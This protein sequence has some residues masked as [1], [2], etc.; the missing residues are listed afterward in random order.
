MQFFKSILNKL[1][2]TISSIA[3]IMVVLAFTDVPYWAY[4][5]LG[6][7]DEKLEN[8]PEYIVVMGGDGMPSPDGL[9]RAYFGA[10]LAL[11]FP[12]AKII[13][14]MPYN[15]EDSTYQLELMKAEFITKSIDSNRISFAPNGYNTRTQA[16]EIGELIP[17]KESSLLI[18]T[19]PEH[20]YRSIASFKKVGFTNIGGSPTFERPPDKEALYKED[21]LEKRKI[22]N[23]NLRYNLWS[24]LQYEIIVIR[25]YLAITYYW[26]K[27]W[28]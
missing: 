20:T 11:K 14:A 25:E 19:S 9:M 26:L 28:I 16:L 7:L 12:K 24:Y 17:N 23:L 10:H 18:V 4:H 1:A 15:V 21:D 8:A 2:Y 3:I 27:G 5:R 22:S 6:V 13:L